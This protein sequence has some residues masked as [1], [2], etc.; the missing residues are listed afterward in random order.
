[1]LNH[2]KKCHQKNVAFQHQCDSCHLSYF[3]KSDL[4]K[5]VRREHNETMPLCNICR[6]RHRY[7]LHFTAALNCVSDLLLLCLLSTHLKCHFLC[8]ICYNTF[9][10][11]RLLQL[12]QITS[13][14]DGVWVKCIPLSEVSIRTA[15]TA[16]VHIISILTLSTSLKLTLLQYD[17]G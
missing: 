12:H 1:M 6:N 8:A 4:T 11:I 9:S 17:H 14:N 3:R 10:D 5:H 16:Y 7:L 15:P 13:C 2:V